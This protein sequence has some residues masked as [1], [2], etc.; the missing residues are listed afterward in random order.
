MI[1]SETMT[2][3]PDVE[4][5]EATNCYNCTNDCLGAWL[6]YIVRGEDL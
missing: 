1:Y 3:T 2:N 4:L 6:Q 5:Q